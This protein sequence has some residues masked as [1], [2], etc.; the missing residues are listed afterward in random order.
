MRCSPTRGNETLAYELMRVGAGTVTR[1]EGH[2]ID[3]A[4][5][6]MVRGH[7]SRRR[8]HPAGRSSPTC[9]SSRTHPNG[10][11]TTAACRVLAVSDSMLTAGGSHDV[12][13][14]SGGA[15]EGIDNGTV[16]SLWRTGSNVVDRVEYS[17]ERQPSTVDWREEGAPADE[18]AGRDRVPHLRQGQLRAGDGRD[19]PGARR[20]PGQTSRRD[21][22]IQGFPKFR[23]RRRPGASSLRA[24][25]DRWMP[26]APPLATLVRAAGTSPRRRLLE[27]CEQRQTAAVAPASRECECG[28][29]TRPPPSARAPDA[30]DGQWLERAG[31]HLVGLAWSGLP[32]AAARPE[33]AVGPCSSAA[34]GSGIRRSRSSAAHE[35]KAPATCPYAR[36]RRRPRP[37]RRVRRQRA[38]PGI[39]TAAHEAALAIGLTLAVLG[40]VRP[41]LSAEAGHRC[42]RASPETGVVVN[43]YPP[44]AARGTVSG[45]Q[46]HPRRARAGARWW[47][48]PGWGIRRA[49]HR[50]AA[51]TARREV[52]ALPGSID[53]PMSR[54]CRQ[55]IRDGAQLV[56]SPDEILSRCRRSATGLGMA[57]E[58]RLARCEGRTRTGARGRP[59]QA[60]ESPGDPRLCGGHWARDPAD[61]DQLGLAHRIGRPPA[62]PPCC[63]SWICKA[64]SPWTH[65][66]YSHKR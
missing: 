33:P 9:G 61:M 4:T 54:G 36:L 17:P 44:G 41:A 3:V 39:D 6:L 10:P 19:P 18:F 11:P 49:D 37:R 31:N 46:P 5:L 28:F 27:R 51:A 45:A 47:S 12:I 38:R 64:T 2:G 65:G 24:M 16:F 50:Q 56:E 40:A 30:G 60:S 7:G 32:A 22:L 52:F 15:R 55:L 63:W 14:I 59:R 62:C 1:G 23:L 25:L 26:N 8:P 29:E 21:L 35:P 57:L 43:E 13:A 53:N 42:G 48:R 58:R 34:T 20:L 66:R